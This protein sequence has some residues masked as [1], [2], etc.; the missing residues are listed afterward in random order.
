[1][2]AYSNM[3]CLDK[4]LYV[5]DKKNYFC[6]E[7]AFCGWGKNSKE[8]AKPKSTEYKKQYNKANK[9]T[10]VRAQQRMNKYACS[11]PVG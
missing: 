8:K 3:S 5:D 6:Y 1:M 4:D 10:H 11:L 2:V 7:D 9:Q